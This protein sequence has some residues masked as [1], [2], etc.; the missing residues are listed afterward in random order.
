M[1]RTASAGVSRAARRV[2]TR[3]RSSRFARAQDGVAAVEFGLIAAPFL[4]LLFAIIETAFVFFA[5]QALEAAVANAGRLVMTGQ[6][7][8]KGYTKTTFKKD[9]VCPQMVKMFNC[10]DKLFIS[11]EN[12][13]KFSD[14]GTTPPYDSKGQLDTSDSKMPYHPGE[15]GEV[16]VVS[17]YYQW[18]IFVPQISSLANQNGSSRLLVATSVFRNEPYK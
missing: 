4:A 5:G 17:F 9:A 7:F 11:V 18:P 16:I 10:M 2:I 14:A 12:Y 3:A 1:F 15:P 8:N 6:A 13:T